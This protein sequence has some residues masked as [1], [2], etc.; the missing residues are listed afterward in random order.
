MPLVIDVSVAICWA[1]GDEQ[2]P[3]A[4]DA[5]ARMRTDEAH[6]PAIWWFELRNVL[7]VNERRRRLSER[8]VTEFL[9]L[10]SALR[11]QIDPI[12][13]ESDL[14]ALSRKHRLSVYDAA[15]L[16]LARRESLPL[17]TLDRALAEAARKENVALLR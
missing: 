6:I 8:D 2:H 4:D 17:A 12:P 11:F 1:M 14:L 13:S 16:E 5:Y 15:Y 7:I 10:I 9:R 3:I